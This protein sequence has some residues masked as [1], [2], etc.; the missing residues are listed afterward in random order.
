MKREGRRVRIRD[1]ICSWKDFLPPLPPGILLWELWSKCWVPQQWYICI[2]A[3]NIR[4]IWCPVLWN[5]TKKTLETLKNFSSEDTVYQFQ[6]T[7]FN[8]YCRSL[9]L[10]DFCLVDLGDTQ[11]KFNWIISGIRSGRARRAWHRLIDFSSKLELLTFTHNLVSG[12]KTHLT[13]SIL[14]MN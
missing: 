6:H 9:L 7:S 12:T 11:G 2:S 8:W 4:Y 5:F 1:E 10:T 14:S 13:I 3:N